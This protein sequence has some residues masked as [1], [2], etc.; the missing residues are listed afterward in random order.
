MYI[1]L[2]GLLNK[3]GVNFDAV[4]RGKMQLN[5]SSKLNVALS[6]GRCIAQNVCFSKRV[7]LRSRVQLF[8]NRFSVL[9]KIYTEVNS[10]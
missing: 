3:R 2:Y 7:T 1:H 6:K 5:E 8:M 10:K 9:K 4:R